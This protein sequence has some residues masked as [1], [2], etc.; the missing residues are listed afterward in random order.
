MSRK[1][2]DDIVKR[3][4]LHPA[5]FPAGQVLAALPKALLLYLDVRGGGAADEWLRTCRLRRGDLAAEPR[6]MPAVTL[7]SALDA[8]V[9]VASREDIVRTWPQFLAPNNLGGWA[10]VLRGTASP[11]QAF[12][13]L[14]GSESE[15]A[16][17]TRWETLDARAGHW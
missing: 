13:R 7:R 17:S 12:T 1:D 15:Y 10:R 14:D 9:S 6:T 16:R 2:V 4:V 5:S 11:Q 3:T 8:F